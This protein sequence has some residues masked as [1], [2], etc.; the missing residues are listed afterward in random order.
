V[1]VI[2]LKDTEFGDKGATVKVADGFARN[3]LFPGLLAVEKTASNAR[4]VATIEQQRAKKL[5][6]EKAEVE[7][8]VKKVAEAPVI[9]LKVKGREDGALFGSITHAQIAELISEH[10][11][12][13]IDRRRVML[14]N[15]KEA[16]TYE[17]PLKMTFGLTATAK[18]KVEIEVE[19]KDEDKKTLKR[20]P[21]KK[22]E[23]LS[24]IEA[25]EAEAQAPETKAE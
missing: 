25:K 17:V 22:E 23:I 24:E 18:I 5:A 12:I 6:R 1:E 11:G 10:I 8:Q 4:H 16:G 2:L 21:R 14:R 15:I 7:A 20:K 3:Y 9:A 19:K 13:T